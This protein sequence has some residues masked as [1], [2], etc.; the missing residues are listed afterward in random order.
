MDVIGH[1][2]AACCEV[3]AEAWVA[4]DDLF[5]SYSAWAQSIGEFP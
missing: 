5:S 2:I 1:F 3:S 4:S